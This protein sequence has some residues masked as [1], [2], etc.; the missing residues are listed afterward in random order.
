MQVPIVTFSRSQSRHPSRSLSPSS[1]APQPSHQAQP[2]RNDWKL[3]ARF[4]PLSACL[5]APPTFHYIPDKCSPEL[6]QRGLPSTD[7]MIQAI[8]HDLER[9][10]QHIIKRTFG[11]H[12]TRPTLPVSRD[13]LERLRRLL[14]QPSLA[15]QR[16]F[17]SKSV[18]PD[19]PL[20]WEDIHSERLTTHWHLTPHLTPVPGTEGNYYYFH[21]GYN[22]TTP[23]IEEK[24]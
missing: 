17:C 20:V 8:R 2:L 11:Y 24:L 19:T 22:F 5:T 21:P 9:L 4:S 14:I 13:E 1:S 16:V 10:P 23:A 6:I 3:P 18:C 7:T 12:T 15:T